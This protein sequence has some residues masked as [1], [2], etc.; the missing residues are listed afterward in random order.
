MST[1]ILYNKKNSDSSKVFDNYGLKLIEKNIFRKLLYNGLHN[2]FKIV[3]SK[4]Q[5]ENNFNIILN[6]LNSSIEI[7]LM[8]EL[9]E[10]QVQ[11]Y[12]DVLVN[13]VDK[14]E[15]YSEYLAIIL[16]EQIS[17]DSY[18]VKKKLDHLLELQTSYWQ[19][20][21][22]CKYSFNIIFTNRRFNNIIKKPF[23]TDIDIDANYLD[24]II[25]E[26]P[27][28][29][30]LEKLPQYYISTVSEMSIETVNNIYKQIPTEYLKYSF[31][32]NLLCTRT[33]CH[34]II[35]NY[36]LLTIAKP[37]FDK[38][39]VVFKYILGYTWL[40]L[41]NEERIL[42]TKIKDNS[43]IIFD[44]NTANKLPVFPFSYDDINQNPYA[45]ILVDHEIINMLKN[46]LALNIMKD[47]T[48]YYG[49]CNSDEFYHRLKIF[50]NGSDKIGML[51]K[52]DWTTCVITGSAMTACGMKYNPLIDVCKIN[53]NESITD[54]D[55]AFFFLNYY[56]NSD[57]DI[58][59]N[60]KSIY[61]FFDT[62]EIFISNFKELYN[63]CKI[64]QVHTATIIISDEFI[65]YELE[66][67]RN[68]LEN[69]DADIKLIK[70]NL[71]NILI[72]NYLYEKYYLPWKIEHKNIITT[73]NKN[74]LYCYNKY[75]TPIKNE[76]FRIY[77]LDYEIN[78]VDTVIQDFEKYMYINDIF[79]DLESTTNKL[80]MKLSESIRFKIS[81][82]HC[83]TFELFKSIN[84][85][86]F[87]VISRF[88]MGMVR[89]YWNG[90]TVK[91][92]PSYITSMMLQLAT[93]Y[94]YFSSIRNPI[95]IINK[96]RTR[97]FGIVLNNYEKIQM[98]YYNT[99]KSTND[100]TNK[101]INIYNINNKSKQS[102]ENMFSS[103]NSNDN[104]FKPGKYFGGLLDD[105]F[106]ITN[107]IT[108]TS[109]ETAFEVLINSTIN[110]YIKLKA[111]NNNGCINPLE[112]YIIKNAFDEINNV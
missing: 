38:Y 46:C 43:R 94:K 45:C 85:D 98:V 97:G 106:Q 41:M 7:I 91:C 88:H 99:S 105:C 71:D 60:Q 53:K 63:D 47:Y 57:V 95:E 58:I 36:E 112:Y 102:I 30:M 40:T 61:D 100:D 19:D 77:V 75:I 62:I 81:S 55:L 6:T 5:I 25:Q 8:T 27:H 3:L 33:H 80:V 110:K 18:Q 14:L 1:F 22:N 17:P 44:I 54:A 66:N 11:L 73:N 82:N 108:I 2:K 84:D 76:E 34:L 52:I 21:S 103:R 107:H 92:L 64:E 87:S 51:D 12:L 50:I 68:I 90:K 89:A 59:C 83:K 31:I 39:I 35:N 96:Y 42:N 28:N 10:R 79:P 56:A 13:E 24:D 32:T 69:N 26:I 101:W 65:N 4:E 111:I 29:R 104:L 37:I 72:K 70:K 9:N 93:D 78:K 23:D 109:F 20:H 86:F 16:Y 15:E 67:L 48:K 74:E 49:V